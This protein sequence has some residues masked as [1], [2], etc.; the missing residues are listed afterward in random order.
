MHHPMTNREAVKLLTGMT[1]EQLTDLGGF[2]DDNRCPI[3]VGLW[4]PFPCP[5]EGAR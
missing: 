3:C 4:S 2:G 1:D 5:Y